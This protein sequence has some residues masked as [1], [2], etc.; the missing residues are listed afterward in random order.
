MLIDNLANKDILS[1]DADKKMRSVSPLGSRFISTRKCHATVR[2]SLP[3]HPD[4]W[5]CHRRH[6]VA[7]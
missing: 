3:A 7:C 2:R 1:F 6:E 5:A 4:D